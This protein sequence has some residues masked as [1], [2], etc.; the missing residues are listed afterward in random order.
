MIA[1]PCTPITPSRKTTLLKPDWNCTNLV[2]IRHGE[3]N[4]NCIY[5]QVRQ[6][7]GETLTA[8]E[9]EKEFDKLHDPDCGLSPKGTRQVEALGHY[10]KTV[11]LDMIEDASN[12]KFYSSPMQRAI[13]T[14][15]QVSMAYSGKEVHVHPNFFES[16]GCYEP[17]EDG[18]TVGIRGMSKTTVESKYPNFY[19]ME[20]MESGWFHLSHKETRKQF[21]ERTEAMMQF[22]WDE[23]NK[24]H[25]SS[26]CRSKQE[27]HEGGAGGSGTSWK[28]GNS[29]EIATPTEDNSENNNNNSNE[30]GILVV[31]H[32]NFISSLISYFVGTNALFA[33]CNTGISHLQLWNHKRSKQRLVSILSTN[34]I[35]HLW[36]DA[37]LQ[38]GEQIFEDHWVQEF[39]APV[40]EDDEEEK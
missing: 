3:S 11:G 9:F 26:A 25:S 1:V 36:N 15:Q 29:T 40:E 10:A 4:N 20:G 33:Q 27:E 32:G 14:A 16:D 22:F 17:K 19:C 23:H 2:F 12:W 37:S 34:R 38:G 30:K 13:L 35:P 6:T 24:L 21:Y 28:S 7:F 8:E 31:A 39:L 18:T 5:E